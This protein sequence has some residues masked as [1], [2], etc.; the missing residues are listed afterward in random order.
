MA[1]CYRGNGWEKKR[2]QAQPYINKIRSV[3]A[4]EKKARWYEQIGF[5]RKC[6]KE[7]LVP[8]GHRVR[9]PESVMKSEY[10][11]RL[12]RRSEKKVIK[13]L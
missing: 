13:R 9:I 12:R 4:I 7:G 6:Q 3:L 1:S 5:L 11:E 10:G 8:K 2:Q